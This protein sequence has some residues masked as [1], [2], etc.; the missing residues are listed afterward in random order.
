MQEYPD[1]FDLAGQRR[2]TP[3]GK[4][5]DSKSH[6]KKDRPITRSEARKN[7]SICEPMGKT[8]NNFNA[9]ICD[10]LDRNECERESP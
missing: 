1:D 10:E 3:R 5:L 2:S 7:L 4:D 6:E 8:L 9:D